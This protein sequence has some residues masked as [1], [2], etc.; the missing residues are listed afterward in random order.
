MTNSH[1]YFV[2][3]ANANKDIL[4][5]QPQNSAVYKEFL[6]SL[7]TLSVLSSS[8]PP[9]V[10][11]VLTDLPSSRPREK[12]RNKAS[13][14][15]IPGT[16]EACQMC[17]LVFWGH[18]WRKAQMDRGYM[19]FSLDAA[20]KSRATSDVKHLL[21]HCV[22]EGKKRFSCST[23]LPTYCIPILTPFPPLFS[24]AFLLPCSY[25][26]R[27]EMWKSAVAKGQK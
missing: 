17:V 6:A 2:F 22:L 26:E 4:L 1:T 18:A 15:Q 21:R 7:L 24:S 20:V 5:L 14:Y 10:P 8:Y 11:H 13:P 25:L 3:E 19:C 23:F 9:P 27:S 12:S 16:L